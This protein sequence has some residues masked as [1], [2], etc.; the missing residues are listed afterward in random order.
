MLS[1]PLFVNTWVS[2]VVVVIWFPFIIHSKVIE[3][4][5]SPLN[6]SELF[7]N[8]IWRLS[9]PLVSE[10]VNVTSGVGWIITESV[11]VLSQPNAVVTVSVIIYV[12]SI[13]PVF[14]GK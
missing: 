10:A 11:I 7:V 9:H 2:W 13:C 3:V 14:S 1:T 8:N 12:L 4:V 6:G 5:S